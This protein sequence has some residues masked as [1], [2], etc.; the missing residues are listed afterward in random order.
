MN[1]PSYS[2]GTNPWGTSTDNNYQP[3]AINDGRIEVIGCFTSTLV[4]Y[5]KANYL[6]FW[7]LSIIFLFYLKTKILI[8]GAG[9]RICQAK[10]IKLTT[11]TYIP[12]QIDGEPAKLTPSIIEIKHKNQA[13]ML[14][15]VKYKYIRF[16]ENLCFLINQKY[17][18]LLHI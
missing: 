4:I 9:E 17:N 16:N 13:I 14:E 8:G 7:D 18:M 2:S 12:I 5:L 15:H 11:S 3:Q 10:Y 1:I 6:F